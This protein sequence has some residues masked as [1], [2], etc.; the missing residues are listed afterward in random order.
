[1]SIENC[2]D[3]GGIEQH[4]GNLRWLR[5]GKGY[6][7]SL[8]PLHGHTGGMGNAVMELNHVLFG[9]HVDGL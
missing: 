9:D 1:M 4:S 7:V 8:G 5:M 3:I 6:Q 2:H